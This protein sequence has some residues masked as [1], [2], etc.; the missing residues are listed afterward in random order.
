MLTWSENSARWFRK[1]AC[2]SC[3]VSAK[4]NQQCLPDILKI[5]CHISP[6]WSIKRIFSSSNCYSVQDLVCKFQTEEGIAKQALSS[7]CAVCATVGLSPGYLT[8]QKV[9]GTRTIFDKQRTVS[10]DQMNTPFF[11]YNAWFFHSSTGMHGRYP[12]SSFIVDQMGLSVTCHSVSLRVAS[13]VL[14]TGGLLGGYLLWL[15]QLISNIWLFL[16]FF[17]GTFAEFFTS[18]CQE[19]SGQ[20]CL[21]EGHE[22]IPSLTPFMKRN[23]PQPQRPGP[24]CRCR[25]HFV[26]S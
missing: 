20:P 7:L 9:L 12:Q 18:V 26:E 24:G 16:A 10:L 4:I 6:I 3:Q 17:P 25:N 23:A 13:A 15:L 2:F 14:W 21:K 8:N 22:C 19:V 11:F 1:C 5:E